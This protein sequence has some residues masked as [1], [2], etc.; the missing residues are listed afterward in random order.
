MTAQTDTLFLADRCLHLVASGSGYSAE[1][2]DSLKFCEVKSTGGPLSMSKKHVN[3]I[4][5]II[6]AFKW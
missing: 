5:C 6:L 3:T 4:Q 1:N 2:N